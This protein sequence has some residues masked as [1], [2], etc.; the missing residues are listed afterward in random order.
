MQDEMVQDRARARADEL[1]GADLENP[2]GRDWDVFK[3]RGEVFMLMTEV[4][5]EPIVVL[6]AEPH[7]AQALRRAHE[8]ITPGYHMTKRHR[9]ALQPGDPWSPPWWTSS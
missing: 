1:P 4:T 9:I 7:D 5:G 3:V 6:K 2:F 8:D